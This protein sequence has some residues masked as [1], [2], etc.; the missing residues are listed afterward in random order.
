[1][2]FADPP[3][4]PATVSECQQIVRVHAVGGNALC[5]AVSGKKPADMLCEQDGTSQVCE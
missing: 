3:Y 2:T 5:N 1:M 4:E